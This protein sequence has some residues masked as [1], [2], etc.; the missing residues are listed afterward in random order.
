V[1]PSP[2]RDAPVL[3]ILGDA[4]RAG[5]LLD[6][7]RR[8]L[9]E[10]LRDR[11]DSAAGLARRLGESRQRLNYHLRALEEAGVVELEEERRRGNCIERVL[12]VV[13][14]R[15]VLDPGALGDLAAD[16]D[17]LADRFS[18]SY[19]VA[20]AAR[21]IRELA[22]LIEKAGRERKR[23]ATAAIQAEVQLA[24]PADFEAFVGDLSEAV[25][26]VVA[27]HHHERAGGRP[28]RVVAGTYPA[29]RSGRE[30]AGDNQGEGR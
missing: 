4:R 3:E 6:P 22:G 28:F 26:E 20:L 7:E 9:V 2:S 1:M 8:R 16:P 17:E 10:A 29:P 30:R 27:K 23:L 15:F 13:A 11:S 5:A 24:R 25:A 12:R 18:A 19:L 14:R 21:A